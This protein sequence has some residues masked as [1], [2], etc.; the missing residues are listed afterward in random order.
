M[1]GVPSPDGGVDDGVDDEEEP[2]GDGAA[3]QV[4]GLPGSGLA[5]WVID[6]DGFEG[7]G[8]TV[9]VGQVGSGFS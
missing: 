1:E 6:A 5:G 2:L 7:S 4:G 9:S 8:T 3:V